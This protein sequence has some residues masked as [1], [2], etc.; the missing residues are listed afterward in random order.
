M[1]EL[2]NSLA[3]SIAA[4]AM[5]AAMPA[6]A[7]TYVLPVVVSGVP[8]V[9]GSFWDSEVR[10][11]KLS[12]STTVT[13]RRAWVALPHGGF[14]DDPA[15]A[16]SWRLPAAE[17]LTML[18]LRGADLLGGVASNRAAIGLEVE[19]E[20]DIHLHVA[21]TE[22]LPPLADDR[23]L[24]CCLPGS[25]QLLQAQA[26]P[27]VGRS[28]ATWVTTGANTTLNNLF[29]ANVGI[30][31]PNPAPLRVLL[32]AFPYSALGP[33]ELPVWRSPTVGVPTAAI[34]IPAWGWVQADNLLERGPM[35]EGTI[36]PICWSPPNAGPRY[37]PPKAFVFQFLPQSD[38]PYYAY[39]SLVYSPT[40]DP[41]FVPVLPG[42][43]EV[44]TQ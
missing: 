35:C 24:P 33:S 17:G 18:I 16:P 23:F 26:V 9:A 41:E 34:D 4:V 30:V 1:R 6:A 29:R 15:S 28:R 10:I 8:G 27:L 38:A 25:G 2:R 11:V 13:V 3:L 36:N 14:E 43:L 21:N 12:P 32:E 37:W 22:G 31:N 44:P 42:G 5:A 40:N 39:V 19:G 20:A 7:E